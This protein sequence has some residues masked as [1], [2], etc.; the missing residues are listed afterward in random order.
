MLQTLRQY[1]FVRKLT[2]LFAPRPVNKFGDFGEFVPNKFLTGDRTTDEG[3][4][5]TPELGPNRFLTTG[6]DEGPL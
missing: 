5:P 3:C 1:K 4:P 6:L 2:D